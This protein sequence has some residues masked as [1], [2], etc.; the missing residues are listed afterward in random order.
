[1]CVYVCVYLYVYIIYNTLQVPGLFTY[2]LK[3]LI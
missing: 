1:M 3:A 2:Y